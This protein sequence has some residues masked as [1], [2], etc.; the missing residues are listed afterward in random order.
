[1]PV[2]ERQRMKKRSQG[3]QRLRL[4]KER[5]SA[6]IQV[7]GVVHAICAAYRPRRIRAENRH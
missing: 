3:I 6:E 4:G 2:S 1:M 7:A 5:E